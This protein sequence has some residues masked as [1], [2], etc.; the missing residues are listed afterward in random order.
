MN[1][2][3]RQYE[4]RVGFT[5]VELLLVM[6]IITVLATLGLVVIGEAQYDARKN[7]TQA[8]IS[9]LNSILLQKLEEYQFRRVPV[10]LAFFANP[11]DA[12]A[13]R[14]LRRRIIGDI[15]NVEM[16][17]SRRNIAF[18]LGQSGT[19]ADAAYP[20]REFVQWVVDSQPQIGTGVV[21]VLAS[22]PPAFATRF[23]RGADP[24]TTPQAYPE[25]NS[26]LPLDVGVT[27]NPN[28]PATYP[29]LRVQTTLSE[30]LYLI[31]ETTEF[32][33][34]LAVESLGDRAF[35]DTDD[36]GFN[37]IVDSWGNPIFFQFE[38]YFENVDQPVVLD[39]NP[40]IAGSTEP[41][42]NLK[43]RL[44]STGNNVEPIFN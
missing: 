28:D 17:R 25:G 21:D 43:V 5:L 18:N 36:D 41:L 11:N 44:V 34:I 12:L 15:I 35:A 22:R 20:G 16:P 26:G 7:A 38:M 14:D 1:F 29:D 40:G 27:F 13:Q 6:A 4:N 30:Y 42:R 37:E 24:A 10:D 33:G 31:L 19:P 9:Q 2:S 8:R 3:A 39:L 23:R 32:N